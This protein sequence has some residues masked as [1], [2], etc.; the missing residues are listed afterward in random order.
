MCGFPLSNIWHVSFLKK[1]IYEQLILTGKRPKR[2]ATGWCQCP[3]GLT[4]SNAS[5][6]EHMYNANIPRAEITTFVPMSHTII[7]P[8]L[9]FFKNCFENGMLTSCVLSN[10][11]MQVKR[12]ILPRSPEIFLRPFPEKTQI[13]LSACVHPKISHNSYSERTRE[14]G[15]EGPQLAGASSY[16][17]GC[18]QGKAKNLMFTVLDWIFRGVHGR[19]HLVS[20]LV[21]LRS[22]FSHPHILTGKNLSSTSL[23]IADVNVYTT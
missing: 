22:K 20:W 9:S 12:S 17:K 2:P 18:Q 14:L 23:I 3:C 4:T 21:L 13:L 1:N 10:A 7:K 5:P 16:S 6:I 15:P 8:K 19:W 11:A